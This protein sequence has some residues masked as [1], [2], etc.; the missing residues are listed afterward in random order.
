[1][2]RSVRPLK[3]LGAAVALVAS[4]ALVDL[5]SPALAASP[6]RAQ[7]SVQT[8]DSTTQLRAQIIRRE[9]GLRSDTPY[10]AAVNHSG[11]FG[12][13][14]LGIPLTASET[15][16]VN[17][18]DR[19]TLFLPAATTALTK[20]HDYAG[21]WIDQQHGGTIVVQGTGGSLDSVARQSIPLDYPLRFTHVNNTLEALDKIVASVVSRIPTQLSF[22]TYLDASSVDVEHNK[23]SLVINPSAPATFDAALRRQYPASLVTITRDKTT[24]HLTSYRTVLSGRLDAGEWVTNRDQG[25][26]CTLTIANATGTDGHRFAVTAG[27]CGNGN[28]YRGQYNY[29]VGIQQTHN[30]DWVGKTSTYCD[31]V[32]IG[33][34]SNT[35]VS[36]SVLVQNN[37]LY[38]YTQTG[39][40]SYPPGLSVCLS[41]AASAEDSTDFPFNSGDLRCGQITTDARSENCG[42]VATLYDPVNTNISPISGDSGGPLGHGG[43]L[44]GLAHCSDGSFSKASHLKDLAVSLSW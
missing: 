14:P 17:H 33:A 25:A 6:A 41:G 12:H 29:S 30:N 37:N 13:A 26:A 11:N 38:T 22:S 15:V 16:D 34:I 7:A 44:V 40:G 27:H 20:H 5:R 35:I 36:T 19:I 31:C 39:L 21:L 23:V 18:R 24:P 8:S 2:I 1:M 43:A 10:V 9:F 3:V 28:Y 32:L 42:G 4:L